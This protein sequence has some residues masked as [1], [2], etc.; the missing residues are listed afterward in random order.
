MYRKRSMHCFNNIHPSRSSANLFHQQKKFISKPDAFRYKPCYCTGHIYVYLLASPH[1]KQLNSDSDPDRDFLGSFSSFLSWTWGI[2]FNSDS[3]RYS[4]RQ[5]GRA[6]IFRESMG[7]RN[8]GGRGLSYRP[9][10]I[11]RLAE[12]IP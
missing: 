11:H 9:A 12:F 8:R 2:N 6:A 1:A 10:R 5:V 7:P 4:S 3:G